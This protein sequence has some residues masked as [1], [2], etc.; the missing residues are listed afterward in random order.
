MIEYDRKQA[1]GSICTTIEQQR[2]LSVL[3][4]KNKIKHVVEHET[5]YEA[6][7]RERT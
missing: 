7:Y 1:S 2:G 3:R 6:F 4:C 5:E